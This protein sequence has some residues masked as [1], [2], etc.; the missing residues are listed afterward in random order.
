MA[1]MENGVKLMN[2]S[3][4]SIMD[5]SLRRWLFRNRELR[6]FEKMLRREGI[7]LDRAV[8][9]DAGCG[10]GMS[11]GMFIEKFH[12]SRVIAFD[13]MPEMIARARNKGLPV[14]FRVGD[15]RKTGVPDASVDAVFIVM[16]LHHVVDWDRV[17]REMYRVL[18]P[19]GV[20]LLEEPKEGG[21][22]WRLLEKELVRTGFTVSQKG[23][24]VPFM[25]RNYL[26]RKP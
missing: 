17:L 3:E 2:S 25:M 14:D 23:N 26:C 15:M 24:A 19:G 10:A 12:P 4:I 9:M 22:S 21:F 8:I 5:G 13:Y 6:V 20:L 16:A 11:T 1:M 18:R 7:S